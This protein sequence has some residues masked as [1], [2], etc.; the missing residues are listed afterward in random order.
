MAGEE[1]K[2][3]SSGGGE[4]RGDRRRQWAKTK[5]DGGGITLR[6]GEVSCRGT[7]RGPC[8]RWASSASEIFSSR[9]IWQGTRILCHLTLV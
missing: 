6:V 7:E 8:R 3:A 9:F 2:W 4:G 1:G 5:V